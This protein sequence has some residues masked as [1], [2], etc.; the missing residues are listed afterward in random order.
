MQQYSTEESDEEHDVG[1]GGRRG[2]SFSADP[3]R[4]SLLHSVL[5]GCGG[6]CSLLFLLLFFLSY[7]GLHAT[8][9]ALARNAVTGVVNF[10]E[11]YHG[12]RNLIGFWNKYLEFP[13]TVQSIEWLD[14]VP[15]KGSTKRDLTPMQVRTQDG[16]MVRLGIVAQYQIVKE[17]VPAIYQ[18]FKLDIEGYFV[19]NLRSSIQ[20]T[21]ATFRATE[22]YEDRLR[23]RSDL[24]KMCSDTCAKDLKGYLTCWSIELLEV[25]LDAK[26]ETQNI[27]EQV[28][29]QKQQTEMM[30]RNASLIRATTEVMVSDFARQVRMVDA[31]AEAKAYNITQEAKSL[32][33]FAQQQ[34]RAQALTVIKNE[35]V[36]G[37]ISMSGDEQLNYLEKL[38]LIADPQ[39]AMVYGKFESASVLLRNGEL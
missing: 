20:E 25:E 5:Y 9:Y 33:A 35:V 28:E 26:I 10:G 16:L 12:G 21:L 18:T 34:A 3:E 22:L 31:A 15:P 27:R 7:Q 6:A 8:R 37:A 13:A 32:A 1:G 23:V 2:L 4:A 24:M 29:K 19:S 14:G 30:I 17:Y 38:A 39:G 36:A 11:V